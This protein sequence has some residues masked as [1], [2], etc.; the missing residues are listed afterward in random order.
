MND[1]RDENQERWLADKT[2]ADTHADF[3]REV[4]SDPVLADEAYAALALDEE[5]TAAAAA[6]PH[7]AVLTRRW[8]WAGGMMAAL[9]AFVILM[10]RSDDISGNLDLRLRSAGQ[11]EAA[12]GIAPSGDLAHFPL[13]FSWHPDDPQQDSRYRWELYDAQAKLRGVAIVADSVLVRPH[14]ETPA[15]SLG[16]WLWLVVELQP[17]GLEGPTSAAVKFTVKGQK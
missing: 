14:S 6:R 9:L 3:E 16:N 10:P 12:V 8:A 17:D 7:R 5:L 4:L 2:G 13:T 11:G 15:D 1:R